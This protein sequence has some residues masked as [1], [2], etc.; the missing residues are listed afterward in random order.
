MPTFTSSQPITAV[1]DLQAGDT[2]IIASERADTV[3]DVRPRDAAKD[4]DVRASAS[5]VVDF[6]AGRLVVR[7]PHQ[8]GWLFG[9]AGAVDVTIELP[10]GS[11]VEGKTALGAVRTSGPLGRC[12]IKA[13]AGDVELEEA[14]ELSLE[15]GAGAI[16]VDRV[17]GRADVSTGSGAVRIRAV[18]GSAKVR[19][20]NGD[21]WIGAVGGD[22]H[23][24][25]ANGEIAVDR[26][27][28]NVAATT[29]N[30]AVRIGG[31]TR[32]NA[33]LQTANGAIEVGVRE[34]TAARLDVLTR[35]GRIEN[36]MSVADAPAPGEDTVTVQARTAYGDILIHRS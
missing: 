10:A 24:R 7:G 9:R 2:H 34:G 33:K 14:A 11:S 20:S 21:S 22:L 36:R 30:G 3:V 28:G 8:R 32:G 16:R 12:R 19:S 18:D 27:G 15:T 25:S 1:V 26:A 6:S 29:A 4:A 35:L 17:T 23:V 5:T 31:L 13:S